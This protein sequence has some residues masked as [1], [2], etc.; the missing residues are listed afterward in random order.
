MIQHC[1]LPA[2]PV[3]TQTGGLAGEPFWPSCKSAHLRSARNYQR[4]DVCHTT[5]RGFNPSKVHEEG[6]NA[7]WC[8]FDPCS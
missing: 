2:W 3:L 1:A 5:P 6:R 4:R 8:R 7:R